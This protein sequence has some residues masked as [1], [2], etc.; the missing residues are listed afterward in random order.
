MI[1]NFFLDDAEKRRTL[2]DVAEIYTSNAY[3]DR[4]YYPQLACAHKK[5]RVYLTHDVVV[6]VLLKSAI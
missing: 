6:A 5:T 2:L 1:L 4:N 3:A